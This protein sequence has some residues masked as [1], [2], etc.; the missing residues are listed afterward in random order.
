MKQRSF[1]LDEDVQA[2][3]NAAR[4]ARGE[5][6]SSKAMAP[7]R[8]VQELWAGKGKPGILLKSLPYNARVALL[9]NPLCAKKRCVGSC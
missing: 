4:S 3:I 9:R 8:G 6:S 7:S 5:R 2:A 1:E